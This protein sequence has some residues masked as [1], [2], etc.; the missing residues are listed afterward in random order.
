MKY[1]AYFLILFIA[2]S[3]NLNA[4]YYFK[5]FKVE[6]G[7]SNNIVFCS[8]QD[9][10]GFMWFG[11]RDGLNRFDGYSFKVFRHNP[12]KKKSLGSNYISSIYEDAYGTLWIGTTKGLYRY[13]EKTEDFTLLGITAGNNIGDVK[14]DDQGNLWFLSGLTLVKYNIKT[15]KLIPFKARDNFNITSICI[16]NNNIWISTGDGHIKK[17]LPENNSFLNFDLFN[18]SK[19][20]SSKWIKKIYYTGDQTIL[21]GTSSQGVKLF[22]IEKKTYQDVLTYNQDK[23]EIY[24]RDFIKNADGEYWIATESGIYIYNPGKN[25]FINL[26]KSNT[27]PYSLADNAVYTLCKDK[28]GGIWAGTYFGGISYFPKPYAPFEKFFPQSL[29]NSISGHAVR[30]ICADKN[31]NLWIG[32]EDAGLNKLDKRTGKFIHIKPTGTAKGLAYSNI[33]GL[34]ANDNELWIG[35]FERGLDVLNIH[36]GNVIKH[37]SLNNGTSSSRSNFIIS[38]YK[39]SA[40]EIFAGTGLGLYRYD[41]LKDN[42]TVVP[43]IATNDFIYSVFEDHT[44]TI[45]AGTLE[46]GVF[47]FRPKTK[48][49]GNYRYHA[50]DS[51]SISSNAINSI[52]EDSNHDLWFA[53]EGGGLCKFHRK[54]NTFKRYSTKDGFPSNIMFRILEDKTKK[55]WI[56]TSRGLTF[57][58]PKLETVKVFTKADGLLTD[59]FNYNSAYKDTNGRMYFGSVDGM[60]SFD[61]NNFSRNR[62]TP[63]IYITGFQIYDR[64]LTINQENS[65]LKESITSTNYIHLDYNQATFSIDFAAL[66]Y[67]APE[68]NEY[69]YKMEGLDD[70]WSYLKTN[71]KIYFTNLPPGIYTFL[72]K[73]A[74]NSGVWNDEP[75]RLTIEIS[76][77]YWASNWAYII[78]FMLALAATYYCV[79]DYHKRQEQKNKRKIQLLEIEKEREIEHLEAEKEREIYHAKIEFFTNVTHEIRTPLTLI[80]APLENI[81][82]N[83]KSP[84]EIKDSLKIMEKNTHHLLDLTNQLLDFRK[85]ESKGFSLS[86]IRVNI[87][88]LLH[89]TFLRFKLAADSKGLTY[90]IELPEKDVLAYVDVAAVTKILSNL[91]SNAI[92]YSEKNVYIELAP[93][94]AEEENFVIRIKN[95]GVYIPEEIRDRIFEPFYRMEVS[96]NELGTGIGLPIARSLTELHKGSLC[97]TSIS[98]LN[99][100]ILTLPARHEKEFQL[101]HEKD[102]TEEIHPVESKENEVPST[103]KPTV[104]LVEDNKDIL[105][106][107]SRELS[108]FYAVSTAPNGREAINI[109]ENT[110]VQLIISDVRMP[111]MDGFELCEYIKSNIE[112]SHIPLILLTSKNTLS[113]KI[114]GLELGADSY[115]EK[116]FSP[117]HLHVQISNLL[118]NRNKI[119]EYFARTP[120]LNMKSIGCSKTDQLFLEKLNEVIQQ[121]M[122]DTDLDIEFLA[123]EMNMSRPTLYRKIKAISSLTPNEMIKIARLKKGAEL[124]ALGEY[125]IFEVCDIVGFSSQSYFAK[126]FQKQFGMTPREYFD[127]NKKTN[128]AD[129]YHYD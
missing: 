90:I 36:T 53:T 29:V 103:L 128:S 99:V 115:I 14:L 54:T 12:K 55:L 102:Q 28:E 7:L 11:T 71:R 120:L 51:N 129:E 80:L 104:L 114:K 6:N 42:F 113:S 96:E 118:S 93:H 3:Q 44:G 60:I 18:Q 116:P 25:D 84:L 72:V 9:K 49:S 91:F 37:Y 61:P 30:E 48:E 67:T 22:D 101:H 50:T 100:F 89:E 17:Y 59:Q 15:R 13:N 56:S 82:K 124:L 111:V 95:D 23:T 83:E 1:L 119:K 19:Y 39:T 107:L 106:Y 27:N 81:I 24:A 126:N 47:Y 46:N 41:S 121:N 108:P 20:T 94:D 57:F 73:G 62:F 88:K 35:T 58:D 75:A 70:E 76:P 123:S 68:V 122:A 64:E 110:M 31:E 4:Q 52:F 112:F 92:K 45:W 38:L 77:P 5:H 85:A 40:G 74:N 97:V 33:H 66:S 26:Q 34:L 43:D 109:I 117:E 10:K 63:P 65:P 21:I 87:S 8:L 78:Y 105:E 86:F 98:Y 2:G 79:R 125:K 69:A 32:T 16:E 127:S